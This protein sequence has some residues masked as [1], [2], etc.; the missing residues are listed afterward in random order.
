M[1]EL[2]LEEKLP[3]ALQA[4][5]GSSQYWKPPI[6]YDNDDNE[7]YSIQ[8]SEF[9]KKSLITI[10]PVLPTIEPEDS[11]GMRDEHPSTIPEKEKSAVSNSITLSHDLTAKRTRI[12]RAMTFVVYA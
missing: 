6:Y 11:L 2:L 3:Q 7:E 12:S 10:T 1:A 5:C 4:L 9:V 8:V